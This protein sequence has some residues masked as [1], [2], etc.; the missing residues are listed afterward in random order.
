MM[1]RVH[2]VSVLVML[3]VASAAGAGAARAEETRGGGPGGHNADKRGKVESTSAPEVSAAARAQPARLEGARKDPARSEKAGQGEA[4]QG[5]YI[6]EI[7]GN[8]VY[9]RSGPGRDYYPVMKLQAGA[10]VQV[11]REYF[12]WAEI[13]PPEGAFSLIHRN[14]VDVGPG[15]LGVVNGDRV[16]V[17][18][19]SVLYPGQKYARQL[20]LN[21][22]AEVRIVGEEGEYYRIEPPE[23]A[24]LWVHADYVERVPAERLAL[25]ES[26]EAPPRAAVRE[27]GA[28]AAVAERPKAASAREPEEAKRPRPH[29]V[30]AQLQSELAAIQKAI[31]AEYSRPLAEQDFR[32]LIERL[33]P[34]AE[35]EEVPSVSAVARALIQ[36]LEARM[37]AIVRLQARRAEAERLRQ[38]SLPDEQVETRLASRTEP[39]KRG[40]DFAGRLEPSYVYNDPLLPRRYRLVDATKEPPRFVAY[41]E[42]PREGPWDPEQFVGRQ[43][44]V[45]AKAVR[46][47]PGMADLTPIVEPLRIEVLRGPGERKQEQPSEPAG[48]GEQDSGSDV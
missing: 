7:T 47:L 48:R 5:G 20:K 33:R 17:R 1:R 28:G 35:Q 37:N 29:E 2:V 8:D 9:V 10:R 46:Y 14:Y 40:F 41:V 24:T 31:E 39:V 36:R 44:G 25:R 15:K 45:V 30:A 27:K 19:G 34:L 26:A 18:A 3:A 4:A 22:G 32:R 43:I 42:F 21:R 23:G 13:V 12:G 38:E 16:I 6:G 11:L